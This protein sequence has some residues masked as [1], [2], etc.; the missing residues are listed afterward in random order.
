GILDDPSRRRSMAEAARLRGRP[1]A[2]ATV[3]D[4]LCDWL[5][6]SASQSQET[7]SDLDEVDDSLMQRRRIKSERQA[8]SLR[9]RRPYMPKNRGLVSPRIQLAARRPLLVDGA[10]WK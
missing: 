5:G 2:A 9:G 3:V 1:D 10:V 6:C 4:D 8:T 7:S